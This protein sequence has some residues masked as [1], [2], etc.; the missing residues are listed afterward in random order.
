[1]QEIY[2]ILKERFEFIRK[3]IRIYYNKYRVEGPPFE[4]GNKVFLLTRNLYIKRLNRKL[5]FKKIGLFKIKKKV[6]KSNYKLDL[7]DSIRIRIKVFYISLLKP[8]LRRARFET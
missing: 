4:E 2:A 7:P 5:D 8:I 3:R 6:S 1:L